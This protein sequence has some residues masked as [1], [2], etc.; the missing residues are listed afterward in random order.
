MPERPTMP[1][2]ATPDR[3]TEIAAKRTAEA[4]ERTKQTAVRTTV[5]AQR[6]EVS[7]DRRINRIVGRVAASA[8]AS[9]SRSSFFCALTY[10]RTYSGDIRRTV[11]PC[12]ART[13]PRW[14]APQ[15]ASIAM[16]H[17][18]NVLVKTG[19]FSGRM[20]RRPATAPAL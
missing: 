3:H 5:A 14:C 9:A 7:A 6:T 1:A 17:A 4:A 19:M 15:H 2:E 13:R 8:I 18:G 10:G 20:R 11:W 16:T 12:G